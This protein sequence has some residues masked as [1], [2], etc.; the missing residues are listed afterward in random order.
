[1]SIDRTLRRHKALVAPRR[2]IEEDGEG[3][4]ALSWLLPHAEVVHGFLDGRRGGGDFLLGLGGAGAGCEGGGVAEGVGGPDELA[5]R[6]RVGWLCW[7]VVR[8]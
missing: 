7:W 3:R 8:G 5:C 1:M 4:V 2:A 6:G